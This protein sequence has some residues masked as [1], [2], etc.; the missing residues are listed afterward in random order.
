MIRSLLQFA[1]FLLAGI[2]Q[3]AH[4]QT[5]TFKFTGLNAPEGFFYHKEKTM[6]LEMNVEKPKLVLIQLPGGNGAF[7]FNKFEGRS[8]KV[9]SKDEFKSE[10]KGNFPD[11]FRLMVDP[12]GSNLPI[13]VLTVDSPY[14]LEELK[15][16][17]GFGFPRDR[18]LSEHQDRLLTV[19]DHYKNLGLPIWLVGHS[20]GTFSATRFMSTLKSMN[21]E[22]DIAGL[23]LS[24]SRDVILAEKISNITT[25]FIHSEQD[26]CWTTPYAKAHQNFLE[27]KARNKSTTEFIQIK[28][29][30]EQQGDPCFTGVHMYNGAY[31]EVSLVLTDFLKRHAGL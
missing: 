6:V 7:G 29:A 10:L 11:I 24:S 1:F 31:D 22:N 14:P 30:K 18:D 20:N 2:A 9:V 26:R 4:A 13:N 21:R 25:L 27:T 15:H 3:F 28:N 5:V 19:L 12:N 8:P 23:I 17:V 16:Q